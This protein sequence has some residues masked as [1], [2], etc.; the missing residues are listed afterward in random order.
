MQARDD[1]QER[2][3]SIFPRTDGNAV[4]ALTLG[5][6]GCWS[7]ACPKSLPFKSGCACTH[8]AASTTCS[9]NVD[10]ARICATSESGYSA[11]GA[12]S[13]CNWSGVCCVCAGGACVP[14]AEACAS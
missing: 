9:G 5:S 14:C 4:S 11:I 10:A 3:L 13:C 7:T 2:F 8:L 6:H 12:T 1:V